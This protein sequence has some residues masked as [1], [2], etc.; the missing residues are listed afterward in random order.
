MRP[1]GD[2][3]LAVELDHPLLETGEPQIDWL[4]LWKVESDRFPGKKVR[5]G[6]RARRSFLAEGAVGRD[7]G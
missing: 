3:G 1:V 4:R 6:Y 2:P 5:E 7:L